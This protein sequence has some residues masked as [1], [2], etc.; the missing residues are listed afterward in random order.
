MSGVSLGSQLSLPAN[1]FPVQDLQMVG[2]LV[3][4]A[5]GRLNNSLVAQ[6]TSLNNSAIVVSTGNILTR[7]FN[8]LISTKP[9]TTGVIKPVFK[10]NNEK[11]IF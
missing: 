6:I 10:V 9:A 2:T 11:T 5:F 7:Y 1:F 8:D 4:R 3:N